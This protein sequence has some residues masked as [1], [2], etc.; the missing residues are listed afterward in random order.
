MTI[1][2]NPKVTTLTESIEKLEKS[3][4]R[5]EKEVN[6]LEIPSKELEIAMDRLTNGV[7]RLKNTVS[8]K[9]RP[10]FIETCT[11]LLKDVFIIDTKNDTTHVIALKILFVIPIITTTIALIFQDIRSLFSSEK[12]VQAKSQKSPAEEPKSKV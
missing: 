5:L 12:I 10:S 9:N 4:I 7:Q 2:L 8:G 11:S 3:T 1:T 6:A